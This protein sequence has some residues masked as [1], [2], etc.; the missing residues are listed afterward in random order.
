MSHLHLPAVRAGLP[1]I[2]HPR[3]TQ[4]SGVIDEI[5][6]RVRVIPVEHVEEKFTNPE[7][8]NRQTASQRDSQEITSQQIE[9]AIVEELERNGLDDVED[10]LE[11]DDNWLDEDEDDEAIVS[12][13]RGDFEGLPGSPRT[14]R[15][16]ISGGEQRAEPSRFRGSDPFG[17]TVG[18]DETESVES[19]AFYLSFH[20][21][22]DSLW[23]IY[24]LAKGLTRLSQKIYR[25]G[26]GAIS[27]HE[28]VEAAKFFLYTHEFFHHKVECLALRMEISHE[29]PLYTHPVY[30]FWPAYKSTFGT[31]ACL[32]EALANGSAL[33]KLKAGSKN[34]ALNDAFHQWVK[35]SLPGYRKGIE[36]NNAPKFDAGRCQL[37]QEYYEFCFGKRRNPDIWYP[38]LHLYDPIIN[39]SSRV[40]YIVPYNSAL[41]RRLRLR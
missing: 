18:R 29:Q 12:T 22:N 8:Q 24:I 31:D 36:F 30:G 27:P 23:G 39:K 32:E 21:Y 15:D 19:L 3:A 14:G 35:T 6:Q 20:F 7:R 28:A 13:F 4:R 34:P 26:G 16:Q 33:T 25:R 40:N 1:G 2:F 17:R 11:D 41:T 9:D 5:R 37:A 10:W 38:A